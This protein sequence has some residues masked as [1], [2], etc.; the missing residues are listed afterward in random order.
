MDLETEINSFLFFKFTTHNLESN[1][2]EYELHNENEQ[3]RK[4]EELA[5]NVQHELNQM[6]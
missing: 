1:F 2:S 4:L 3:K 5:I 6:V